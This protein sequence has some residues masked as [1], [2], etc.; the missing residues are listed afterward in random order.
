[1]QGAKRMLQK[2]ILSLQKVV[3]L[4]LPLAVFRAPLSAQVTQGPTTIRQNLRHDVSLPLSEL[5]KHAPPPELERREVEPMKRIPLPAG[6]A[7][8]EED[9]LR[10][11]NAPTAKSPTVG[12]SFEGLGKGQYGFSITGAPP[13]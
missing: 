3:I 4:L 11:M 12:L 9:P 6:L 13:D 8:L 1:M 7:R 2:S 5:I 10:Q